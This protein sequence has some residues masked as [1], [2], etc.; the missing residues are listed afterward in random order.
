LR[1]DTDLGDLLVTVEVGAL[2]EAAIDRA[3]ARGGARAETFRRAGLLFAAS[4]VLQGR[5]RIVG[6]LST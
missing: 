1:E 2:P 6:A 5:T 4:L 3:L